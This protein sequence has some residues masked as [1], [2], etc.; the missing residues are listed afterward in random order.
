M[1]AFFVIVGSVLAAIL[2][3]RLS[4][5][6]KGAPKDPEITAGAALEAVALGARNLDLQPL[7]DNLPPS[8]QADADAL[9]VQLQESANP[10]LWE[11]GFELILRTADLAATPAAEAQGLRESQRLSDLLGFKA[12]NTSGPATT[13][14]EHW[15]ARL[16]AGLRTLADDRLKDPDNLSHLDLRELA[17][18][19]LPSVQEE[20]D[21]VDG[22]ADEPLLTNAWTRSLEAAAEAGRYAHPG[23]VDFT[24]DLPASLLHGPLQE[25]VQ[26][27]EIEGR[28]V[29]TE[30]A[31]LIPDKLT[32]IGA[33][34]D[35]WTA[36]P[37]S[38]Q[39]DYAKSLLEATERGL[40]KLEAA[41]TDP[42]AFDT[43]LD[44][45]IGELTGLVV[46]QKLR[47]MFAQESHDQ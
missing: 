37:D 5:F 44:G 1:K 30:L 33:E 39:A 9:L 34:L 43:A 23:Q 10:A 3:L 13:A 38:P 36:A 2:A 35:N 24:L 22:H 11:L 7:W 17:G 26:L 19:F 27:V 42:V 4:G 41:R 15:R 20:L 18:G 31:T 40:T 29:P 12:E 6:V 16:A 47:A 46:G 14:I 32:A 45:L 21:Q 25:H 8:W 28:F